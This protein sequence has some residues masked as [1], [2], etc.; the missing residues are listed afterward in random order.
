MTR[1]GRLLWT[2]G[3]LGLL[4]FGYLVWL[5]QTRLTP[6]PDLRPFDAHLTGYTM[7]QARDY[8]AAIPPATKALYLGQFR[9]WDTIAPALIA[10]TLGGVIWVQGR[11][12]RQWVRL[13][14][15]L[16]PAGYLLM[17][18]AENAL[19]ADLLR[20]GIDATG[21]AILRASQFTQVKWAF[22]GLALLI[23]LWAWLFTRNTRED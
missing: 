17:D 13:L 18:Y 22:L 23:T 12:L 10:F 1:A 15:L 16:A 5:S 14:L 3:V 7:A 21:A 8:L 4:S 20:A 9:L 11:G 2:T 6:T 19:V